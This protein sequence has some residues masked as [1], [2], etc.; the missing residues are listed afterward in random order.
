MSGRATWV[1][2][3]ISP[4]GLI[5][6]PDPPVVASA[7]EP[8]SSRTVAD[9][10][11]RSTEADGPPAAD[12]RTQ[13]EEPE[14]RQPGHRRDRHARQGAPA[15]PAA[16]Y[17]PAVVARYLGAG[18]RR[19]YAEFLAGGRIAEAQ[20]HRLGNTQRPVQLL[21]VQERP[22]PGL[23][24]VGGPALIRGDQAVALPGHQRVHRHQLE[25][26]VTAHPDLRPHRE[27]ALLTA[28]P[29]DQD[30]YLARAG[31]ARRRHLSFCGHTATT[32][33]LPSIR[34]GSLPRR[35]NKR[36]A[37]QQLGLRGTIWSA[38]AGRD[39]RAAGR[40][41]LSASP[42]PPG[43]AVDE[44]H[45]GPRRWNEAE[46]ALK[47]VRWDGPRRDLR[48]DKAYRCPSPRQVAERRS[49]DAS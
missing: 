31:L 22:P 27:Y 26:R 5:S 2:V 13:G 6:V 44:P 28:E 1:L 23:V 7:G 40:G 49:S 16:Q 12:R 47:P 3:R 30:R 14:R 9:S 17:P 15:H 48:Y 42:D 20:H 4:V 46:A 18:Q 36:A 39:H 38:M 11:C 41:K 29:G 37:S 45:C 19:S 32:P 33:P 24:D 21:A 34:P 43:S 8:I 25:R 10:A 35:R